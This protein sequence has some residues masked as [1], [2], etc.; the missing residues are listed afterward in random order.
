MRHFPWDFMVKVTFSLCTPPSP[1]K[2]ECF[3]FY[4]SLEGNICAL[5]CTSM[6]PLNSVRAL[7]RPRSP[8]SLLMF[9]P[10]LSCEFMYSPGSAQLNTSRCVHVYGG[11]LSECESPVAQVH[12]LPVI[13]GSPLSCG[14][15]PL[16]SL[17]AFKVPGTSGSS[18]DVQ[19]P[20]LSE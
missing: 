15:L 2:S 7:L 8:L 6:C 5:M 18:T 19:F 20:L 3:S 4:A 16:S 17:Y 13:Q 12:M 14:S 1:P 9:T 10:T 11:G